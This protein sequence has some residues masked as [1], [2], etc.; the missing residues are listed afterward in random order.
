MARILVI[1]DESQI[2]RFLR[3]V[4]E[5]EGHEVLEAAT[6]RAGIAEAARGVPDVVVLDL[7]LPD[8]DGK[9][10]LAAIRE[11]SQVPVLVLSVRADE[12]EKIAALDAG[13]QDYVTKP[14]APESFSRASAR[15]CAIVEA[16][17]RSQSSR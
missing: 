8:R 1:D 15:F 14:F 17:P 12:V 10:V 4:L 13:A 16:R 6:G 11:W 2:R 9:D 3:I 5:A 7:G